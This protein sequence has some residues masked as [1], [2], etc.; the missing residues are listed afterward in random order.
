MPILEVD[1][2]T[3]AQS[4][5]IASFLAKRFGKYDLSHTSFTH[6]IIEFSYLDNL[7][8]IHQSQICITLF[9]TK[10]LSFRFLQGLAGKT[11]LDEAKVAMIAE[12]AEELFISPVFGL[13]DVDD[14]EKRVCIYFPT[15]QR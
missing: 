14:K 3:N 10:N 8:S 15:I 11:D 6:E 1:G 2:V 4:K 12:T 7:K 5:V 13:F 9:R